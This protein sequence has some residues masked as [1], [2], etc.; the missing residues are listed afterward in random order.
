VLPT[1]WLL[2]DTETTCDCHPAAVEKGSQCT[3]HSGVSEE[4][5]EPNGAIK[6]AISCIPELPRMKTAMFGC[7]ICKEAEIL[8]RQEAYGVNSSL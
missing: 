2:S 7:K 1:Q 6:A 8:I 4:E 5:K 3:W